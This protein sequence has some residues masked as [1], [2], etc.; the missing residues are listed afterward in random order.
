MFHYKSIFLII[1]TICAELTYS[2]DQ[3]ASCELRL[4][5]ISNIFVA[6]DV[7]IEPEYPGGARE[8]SVYLNRIADDTIYNVCE[9]L[10]GIL[11][12]GFVIDEN[13]IIQ[14]PR[15]LS[16]ENWT[17]DQKA[18]ACKMFSEMPPWSPGKCENTNIPVFFVIPL[19]VCCK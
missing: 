5:T 8:L 11:Y 10:Y 15:I 2:Q 9:Q 6:D 7:E 13:G 16:G 3:S 12:V 19:R 14:F 1:L 17:D 4:D 18:K